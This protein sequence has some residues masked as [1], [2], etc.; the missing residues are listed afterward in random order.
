V[1]H[2]RGARRLEGLLRVAA[3]KS[4]RT[5]TAILDAA[6]RLFRERGYEATT[7]RAVA[8]EAGVSVGNAY[9]YFDSKEQLIHSFYGRLQ[10]EHAALARGALDAARG[11]QE[12]ILA[13]NYS[14]LEVA[15]PYRNF[16]GKFFKT[17]AE[18]ASPLSPFSPE[19]EDFRSA[20][21]ALWRDVVHGAEPAV[22]PALREELPGLLW[23]YSMGLVLFWVHDS[24]PEAAAT[25][26]LMAATAP[27][28]AQAVSVAGLPGLESTVDHILALVGEL[29][30]LLRPPPSGE[31]PVPALG[32]GGR[33]PEGPGGAG[34][35]GSV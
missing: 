6:L 30:G 11:L 4:E 33:P 16:A 15:E 10:D 31:G 7:M 34:T 26:R 28:L 32:P 27:L 18:P 22:P 1:A 5:R 19:S 25:R 3:N 24:T 9:Y 35:T 2:R 12:R 29:R 23:L 17:A 8:T 21:T 20:G 13:T 14:W